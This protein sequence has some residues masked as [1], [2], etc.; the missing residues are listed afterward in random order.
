LEEQGYEVVSL[1]IE[2]AYHK[3]LIANADDS[4]PSK[5]RSF[6]LIWCSEVLEHLGD[7]EAAIREFERVLKEGGLMLL[8]TPNS[9]F[10]LYRLLSILGFTPPR[11]QNPDH[12]QFFHLRDIRALFPHGQI[13]GFFP[14]VGIKCT[15]RRGIGCLSPTFIICCQRLTSGSREDDRR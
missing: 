14:Y 13:L 11:I 3:G 8:A 4:L 5:D 6:D 9:Y 10:W 2:P 15:I 12:K 1:D 7:P